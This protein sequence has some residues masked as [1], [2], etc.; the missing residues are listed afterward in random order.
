MP[1]INTVKINVTPQLSFAFNISALSQNHFMHRQNR[2]IATIL[3]MPKIVLSVAKNC[4]KGSPLT[5]VTER[6]EHLSMLATVAR[7]NYRN[8]RPTYIG[9]GKAINDLHLA[10]RSGDIWNSRNL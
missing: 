7:A 3:A 8:S 5:P 4:G 1:Y 10:R 6:T 2:I 9:G